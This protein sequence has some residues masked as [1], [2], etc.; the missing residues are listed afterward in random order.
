LE[1]AS[2]RV[3]TAQELHFLPS[4]TGVD[5]DAQVHNT[6]TRS[7]SFFGNRCPEGAGAFGFSESQEHFF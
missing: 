4:T 6:D 2:A 3:P 1:D 7:N 5:A